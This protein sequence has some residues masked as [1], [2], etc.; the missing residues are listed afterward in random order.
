MGAFL[1]GAGTSLFYDLVGHGP[2]L[3]CQP[4]GPG[5][6]G[7]YLDELGGVRRTLVRLD[8]RGVG[9]SAAADSYSY[10]E[11]GLDLEW[12]RLQLGVARIDLLGHAAGAWPVIEFAA[13]HPRGVGRVVLLTP[14]RLPLPRAA[15][16]PSQEEL[17]ARWFGSEPWYPEARAHWDDAEFSPAV[18]PALYGE[19]S[20]AVRAHGSRGDSASAGLARDGFWPAEGAEVPGLEVPGLEVPGLEVPELEVPVTIIAGDR[21]VITGPVVP[22]ILAGR[23]ADAT[24][25]WIRGAGHFPWVTHPEA[26]AAAIDTALTQ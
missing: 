2:L 23:F 5:R 24:V 11:L 20:A 14:S 6:P 10:R 21:D 8:P 25:S 18:L 15:G 3:V 26:T 9:R 12:L 13:R 4:G 1:S 7:S 17:L 22:G 19:D 16:E